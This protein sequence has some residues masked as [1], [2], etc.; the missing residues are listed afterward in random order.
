M[1]VTCKKAFLRKY[2]SVEYAISL[3][4]LSPFHFEEGA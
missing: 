2:K 1:V 3:R 4:A